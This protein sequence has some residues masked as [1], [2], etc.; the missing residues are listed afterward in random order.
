MLNRIQ[1]MIGI[2]PVQEIGQKSSKF[3]QALGRFIFPQDTG[4]GLVLITK[5][6]LA[7]GRDQNIVK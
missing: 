5:R 3:R 6:V 7:F 1:N 2:D 4:D